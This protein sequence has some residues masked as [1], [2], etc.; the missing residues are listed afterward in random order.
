[1]PR[2]FHAPLLAACVFVPVSASAA[3]FVSSV[4]QYDVGTVPGGYTYTDSSAALGKPQAIVAAQEAWAAVLNPFN[5]HYETD[6]LVGIGL[7]GSIAFELPHAVAVL[8]R[9]QI[10]VFAYAGLYDADY[11]NGT[12]GSPAQTL[13]SAEYGAERSAIVEVGADLSHMQSLGR[14]TF[15]LPGNYYANVTSPSQYPSPSPAVEADFD[16]P[17]TG[18]LSSFDGENFSQIL[19]TLDGSAGGTWIT[20]PSSLDVNAINYIRFSDPQWRLADGSYSDLATSIYSS[21]QKPADLLLNAVWAV[22]EPGTAMLLILP[23]AVGL[24]RRRRA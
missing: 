6:Q 24:L 5:Q 20:L 7:G 8:N 15:D 3:V 17:F 12:V 16:K 22:P 13:A 21:Q 14:I 9:P 18:S 1:M 10:G 19:Q 23:A 2:S 4:S 11:P